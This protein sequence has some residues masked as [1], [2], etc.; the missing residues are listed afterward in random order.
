MLELD[1]F[2]SFEKFSNRATDLGLKLCP[3]YISA[4]L[5]LEYLDQADGPYLTVA[6]NKPENN[7]DFPNGFYLRNF[8]N[9]LWLRGYKANGFDGWLGTNE[10]IFIQL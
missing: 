4:F 9:T 8:E 7:E 3:L 6:S 1:E 2:C 5:R 10:F